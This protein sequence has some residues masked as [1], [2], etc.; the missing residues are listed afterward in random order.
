M[1]VLCSALP[2]PQPSLPAAR[3]NS[4]S[5]SATLTVS[6]CCGR[7]SIFFEDAEAMAECVRAVAGDAGLFRLKGLGF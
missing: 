2:F 3:P 7:E 4:S 5:D 1:R 6:L